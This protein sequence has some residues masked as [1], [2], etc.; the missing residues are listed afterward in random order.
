M[1]PIVESVVALLLVT[2]AFFA[3]VGSVGLVRFRDFYR[4][5]HAPTKT[6]TLGVGS[7]LL[8]SSVWFSSTHPGVSLHELLVA[9]FLFVTAPVSAHLLLQAARRLRGLRPGPP[10]EGSARQ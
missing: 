9:G 1:N 7:I 3:L 10:P 5:V 6:T 2:G 8:A 4:R